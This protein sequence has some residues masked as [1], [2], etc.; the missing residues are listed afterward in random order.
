MAFWIVLPDLEGLPVLTLGFHHLSLSEEEVSHVVVDRR[1]PGCPLQRLS[2]EGFRLFPVSPIHRDEGQ[3]IVGACEV[4]IGLRRFPEL[5]F[6]FLRS[7]LLLPDDADVI[8]RFGIFGVDFNRLLI[9]VHGSRNIPPLPVQEA[10]PFVRLAG[11]GVPGKDPPEAGF[12]FLG[13][14]LLP[15]EAGEKQFR[16]GQ[17]RCEPLGLI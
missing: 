15:I 16:V 10:Q 11:R 9:F 12:R 4:R 2:Q 6:G 3:V 13:P 7:P 1:I 17:I 5:R 8:V 14:T